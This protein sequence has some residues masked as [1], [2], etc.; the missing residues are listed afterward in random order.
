MKIELPG[1]TSMPS[2]SPS[3]IAH[4][5]VSPARPRRDRALASVVRAMVRNDRRQVPLAAS[6]IPILPTPDVN[7]LSTFFFANR[8]RLALTLRRF[9]MSLL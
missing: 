6:M 3:R 5:R 8:P 9:P 4:T 7:R 1:W 2:A